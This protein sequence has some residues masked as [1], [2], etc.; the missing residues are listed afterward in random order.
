M[1]SWAAVALVALLALVGLGLWL[2]GQVAGLAAHRRWP[3]VPLSAACGLA[4]RMP[5]H[6]GDPAAGWPVG[7]RRQLAGPVVFYTVGVIL[8]VL[9]TVIVFTFDP[10]RWP[11][12]TT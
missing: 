11:G 1:A 12:V 6:V 10:S 5:A 2:T 8:F 3:A 9:G 4:L 7:V